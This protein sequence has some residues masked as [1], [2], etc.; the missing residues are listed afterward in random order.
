MSQD[1]KTEQRELKIRDLP[2]QKDARGGASKPSK[3]SNS[4]AT[5]PKSLQE[6]LK[7]DS[8]PIKR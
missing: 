4:A 5:V 2:P 7:R 8:L 6:F 3:N 1:R